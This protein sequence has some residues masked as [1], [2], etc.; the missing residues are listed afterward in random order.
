MPKNADKDAL[1]IR[2][3]RCASYTLFALR[4]QPDAA[5]AS[6][7]RDRQEKNYPTSC[8]DLNDHPTSQLDTMYLNSICIYIYTYLRYISTHAFLSLLFK[9]T[10]LSPSVSTKCYF[11]KVFLFTL[12]MTDL[13]LFLCL[14]LDCLKT[15][16]LWTRCVRPDVF[17]FQVFVYLFPTRVA[18]RAK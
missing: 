10:D 1:H 9:I 8:S 18:R 2:L 12:S 11:K 7:D 13:Y 17:F 15:S 3:Q 16:E 6:G 5:P 14:V 4:L